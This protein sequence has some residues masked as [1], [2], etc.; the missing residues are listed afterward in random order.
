M[1]TNPDELVNVIVIAVI[2]MALIIIIILCSMIYEEWRKNKLIKYVKAEKERIEKEVSEE[3][4]IKED[5]EGRSFNS[6]KW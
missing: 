4:R 2:V 1:E 5:K 3:I 6:G